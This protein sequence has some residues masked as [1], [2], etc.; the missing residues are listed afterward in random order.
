MSSFLWHTIADTTGSFLGIHDEDK[1]D[2]YKSRFDYAY[3]MR[4]PGAIVSK[5]GYTEKWPRSRG[6]SGDP[7]VSLYPFGQDAAEGGLYEPVTVTDSGF[8]RPYFVMGRVV[9]TGGNPL[10]AA[11]VNLYLSSTEAFVSS[12]ITNQNGNYQLPTPFAGQNHFV[13]ANYAGNT[14]V[15]ASADTLTPNF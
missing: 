10:A 5:S 7:S 9:D 14:Y 13:Y 6:L 8:S 15:G 2:L 4:R 11:T 3:Q 1:S 12:G